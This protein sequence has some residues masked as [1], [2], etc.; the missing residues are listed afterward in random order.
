MFR[1]GLQRSNVQANRYNGTEFLAMSPVNYESSYSPI[2]RRFETERCSDNHS[3]LSLTIS[4]P[5]NYEVGDVVTQAVTGAT[6]AVSLIAGNVVTLESLTGTFL[7]GYGLTIDSKPLTITDVN[8]GA[9]EVSITGG[10]FDVGIVLSASKSGT[11]TVSSV[12]LASR[13]WCCLPLT[14]NGSVVIASALRRNQES[15]QRLTCHSTQLVK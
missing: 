4:N 7:A 3:R 10:V 6:G 12:N 11:G 14:I 15:L 9:S 13:Q 5:S 1:F 2:Y 8:P